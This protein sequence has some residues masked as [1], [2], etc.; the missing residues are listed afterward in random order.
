MRLQRS[1]SKVE[2]LSPRRVGLRELRSR[3][4]NCRKSC[5]RPRKRRTWQ[6]ICGRSSRMKV[7]VKVR[8]DRPTG[9]E[10]HR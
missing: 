7:G 6:R 10:N 8:T 2:I 4:Q 1:L 3:R 5:R 9:L